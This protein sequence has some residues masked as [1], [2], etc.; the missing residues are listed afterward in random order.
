M[1]KVLT[2][3]SLSI[4]LLISSLGAKAQSYSLKMANDQ[5]NLYNYSKAVEM[6]LKIYKK[7]PTL[8]V[9]EHIA[10][11]YLLMRDFKNAET[12][13]A[14]VVG[15]PESKTEN[16][17]TYAE[18][19]KAN[20]KYA[21]ARQQYI[22]YYAMSLPIDSVKLRFFTASCDSAIKWIND[23]TGTDVNNEQFLNSAKSDWGAIKYNNSVVFTSDRP[24]TQKE[25]A[26]TKT[27][28]G[29]EINDRVYGWTGNDYLSLYES[30]SAATSV[31]SM[32]KHFN[33]DAGTDYHVGAPS[34]TADGSQMF[35]TLTRIPK[36]IS[37]EKGAIKTIN[38]EIY[39]STK[40][41]NAWSKPV[42]FN[43]NNVQKYSVGD[44]FI[45][46]DG[47]TLYFVSNMP[48]GIGGTD[49]YS[50]TKN[51][52]GVWS[53]LKNLKKI[54]TA[55]N[56]RT[57]YIL[58][59][60]MYFSSDGGVG[61]GGLDIYRSAIVDEDLTTPVN[62]AYP[63]NS[64]QD[65]FAYNR[66]ANNTGYFSSNRTGG[67]GSDDIYSYKEKAVARI[68]LEGYVYNK[69]T[70]LPVPDAT[71]TLTQS[72]GSPKVVT[73]DDNG[74]FSYNVQTGN[75]YSLRGERSG[76]LSDNAS[77]S[78]IGVTPPKTL[79][80]N[81]YIDRIE[82]NK[83]IRIENIYYDLDKSDIRPEAA[84]ELNKIIKIMQDN[85]TLV[86]EIGSHT[87]SR[88]DD[89]YN[90][91]L[92]RRRSHAVVDYMVT[93]GDID[94]ERIIAHGYGETRLLNKCANGVKC[95]EAEHQLNR[96][97]EFTILKY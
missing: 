29:V 8:F 97:T 15:M 3:I 45:S 57:P 76:F 34:F 88:A 87:D 58:D 11:C 40:R 31:A 60:M 46:P 69:K 1:K 52:D 32:V 7:D 64:P 36:N 74:H 67:V 85:P 81:L 49:I 63:T 75:T 79:R 65:D 22:Q 25:R 43:L 47:K 51:T 84:V 2:A 12:W 10:S 27:E 56:E 90:M 95:S 37:K 44:P 61:M 33:F 18:M 19:L 26:V 78:T 28:H 70:I 82:L 72:N 71:V 20:S 92:S 9:A 96:R 41:G 14:V 5:Y 4:C 6:Y 86:I 80:K 93:T 16:T 55:G 48:G 53:N 68:K 30:N 13:Y 17:Y 21:E 62:L 24:N 77:V 39:S 54:N 91:A 38:L 73:T 23:P 89:D 50:V 42:P 66:Y 35:F 83:A 94:P 59:K